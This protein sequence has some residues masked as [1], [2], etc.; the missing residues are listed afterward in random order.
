MS[1]TSSC[2]SV[3]Q[4]R[5]KPDGDSLDILSIG[6]VFTYTIPS[7]SVIS[8]RIRHVIISNYGRDTDVDAAE[9]DGASP[10]LDI[11][12][13]EDPRFDSLDV[14]TTIVVFEG[15]LVPVSIHLHNKLA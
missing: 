15:C 13:R 1:E 6:K 5:I 3:D 4:D 8:L 11:F 7:F 2:T 12:L 10:T 14:P 9:I